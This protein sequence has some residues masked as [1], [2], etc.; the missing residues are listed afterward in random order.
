MTLLLY[1]VFLVVGLWL[2]RFFKVFFTGP[3]LGYLGALFCILFNMFL[4]S[5][6]LGLVM[7]ERLLFIGDVSSWVDEYPL[8]L[9][10]ALIGTVVQATFI[11]VKT[12]RFQG[13]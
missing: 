10:P 8:V 9:W 7:Y 2:G 5:I 13:G 11:P 6:H 1:L 4:G 12:E 3:D